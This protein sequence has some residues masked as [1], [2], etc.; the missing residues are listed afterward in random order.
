[1]P[2]LPWK[3]G[4]MKYIHVDMHKI[5]QYVSILDAFIVNNMLE[6]LGWQISGSRVPFGMLV[7]GRIL[8]LLD[9]SC[10]IMKEMLGLQQHLRMLIKEQL[11]YTHDFNFVRLEE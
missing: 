11:A 3:D 9:C 6:R 8:V 2:L 4:S 7:E 5:E 10:A 1:M